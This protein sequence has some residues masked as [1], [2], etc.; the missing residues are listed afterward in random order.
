MQA[1]KANA[2]RA[3]ERL[4]GTLETDWYGGNADAPAGHTWDG[5]IHS[6]AVNFYPDEPRSE[7]WRD[8]IERLE[9][10]TPEPCG[11]VECSRPD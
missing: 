5:D 11:C 2:R 10:V 7:T 4:G 1:T 6:Y 3:V 8:L 9:G